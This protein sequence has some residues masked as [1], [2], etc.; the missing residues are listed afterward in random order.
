MSKTS[1][2]ITVIAVNDAPV[3]VADS[4]YIVN[5]GGTLNGSSVLANDTD[6]ESDPLTAVLVSGPAHAS[7]FTLNADGTFTYV[8]DGSGTTSD[9]FTYKVNDGTSDSNTVTVSIAVNDLCCAGDPNGPGPA[10]VPWPPT[11]PGSTM[12]NLRGPQVE[13][14]SSFWT[15]SPC[16]VPCIVRISDLIVKTDDPENPCFF[17]PYPADFETQTEEIEEIIE[18]A[19]L[20]DD[21]EALANP[22]SPGRRR[23]AISPFLQLRPQPLGAVYN[24]LR[25]EDQPVILTGRELARYFESETPGLGHRHALNFLIAKFNYS[26]PRQALIWAALDMAIYS[27]LLAAWHYKWFT[28]RTDVRYRPRP[29]EFDYRVSVLF[30]RAVNETESADGMVR[31]TPNPSPGTPRH[32]SYPSGHSTYAGAASEMLSFFFPDYTAEFDKLADNAGMARLWAGIHWRSDHVQGV[33]LGR[34]V[35]REIIAKLQEGCICPPD[36]CN[37]PPPCDAPPTHQ[38]LLDCSATFSQCCAAE[39]PAALA[40]TGGGR[41]AKGTRTGGGSGG[42]EVS[43]AALQEQSRGPQ[44][45]AKTAGSSGDLTGQAQGPQEGAGPAG[46]E[47]AQEEKA[48]G[49]QEGA[50]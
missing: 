46:S 11:I 13:P 23:L 42:G 28:N 45:G 34:C 16:A 4:G 40:A 15:I 44:Q 20:R 19:S 39:S 38:D 47:E 25:S 37:T 30:N 14:Q 27:A 31:L 12:Y 35:A 8:H 48:K 50:K 29:I 2:S 49:P 6:P 9:S 22:S 5:K 33:R 41:S 36:V 43:S 26:P 32:P 17:P 1:D 24:R 18:L 10:G 21:P 7:S 3:A